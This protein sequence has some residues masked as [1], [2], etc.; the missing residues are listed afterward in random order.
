MSYRVGID[1]GGTKVLIGIVDEN[2]KILASVK[3]PATTETQ[4]EAIIAN[5]CEHLK[6][7]LSENGI[8][9]SEISFFGAGVPGTARL[10]DG[11]IVYCPN[12]NLV[13]VPAGALFRKYLGKD[14][15]IS[16]DCRLAAWGEHL[17]G[18]GQ[19]I[20]DLACITIGTGIGCGIV[21]DGKILHG[22]LNTAGEIGHTCVEPN[23]RLCPCGNLGCLERYSS[24]TGILIS[25]RE[26]MPDRIGENS[27]TEDVFQL[28]Y[29]GDQ[30]ARAIIQDAVEKLVTCIVNMMVLL[31]LERVIISGG[32][33]VH[34]ELIIQPLIA[35]VQ[36]RGYR[37][38]LR[39][40]RFS[41]VKA[42][43]GEFAPMI[44]AAFLDRAL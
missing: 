37:T 31:S 5:I 34:D 2:A 6:K 44:G 33:C 15:R 32:M 30:T 20:Q 21:L 14:V 16:Q 42:S 25:A 13:D 35:G 43:L 39:D 40:G 4:P 38:W 18:S 11:H 29:G 36:A 26:Q 17:F 1:I 19:G 28:A 8:S 27:R 9:L 23:G 24:G 10:S 7:L 41:M 3:I 12:I 22:A